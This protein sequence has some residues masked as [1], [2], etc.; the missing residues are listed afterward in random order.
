L[1][2]AVAFPVP[3]SASSRTAIANSDPFDL[4][5]LLC[6]VRE[7]VEPPVPTSPVEHKPMPAGALPAHT[8]A[9]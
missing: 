4:G 5:T 8:E 2:C 7:A 6:W 3:N 1:S 9:A